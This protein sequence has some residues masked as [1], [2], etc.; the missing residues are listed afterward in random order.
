MI[1]SSLFL[2]F[3]INNSSPNSLLLNAPVFWG[4]VTTALCSGKA[5]PGRKAGCRADQG[6]PAG[7]I[8]LTPHFANTMLA[9]VFYFLSSFKVLNIESA[10]LVP[11]PTNFDKTL[12]CSLHEILS[13]GCG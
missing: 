11:V 4:E 7:I 1:F 9:D 10:N 3:K 2:P 5:D 8:F 12:N 6:N 13:V